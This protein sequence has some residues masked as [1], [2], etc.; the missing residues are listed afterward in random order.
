MSPKS[1]SSSDRRQMTKKP[2]AGAEPE[3]DER[4]GEQLP[5]P[6]PSTTTSAA[7]TTTTIS[8]VARDSHENGHDLK[9]GD[10]QAL[11]ETS[12]MPSEVD[13]QQAGTTAPTSSSDVNLDLLSMQAIKTT[14]TSILANNV[15][16]NEAISCSRSAELRKNNAVVIGPSTTSNKTATDPNMQ[17]L[18]QQEQRLEVDDAVG[19]VTRTA[20]N[21]V[22]SSAP[23]GTSAAAAPTVTTNPGPHYTQSEAYHYRQRIAEYNKN[24][25]WC[26]RYT[27]WTLYDGRK[28]TC[29]GF[30]K[31]RV[32]GSTTT[33]EG[34][35]HQED[36]SSSTT[37]S[38]TS[39]QTR[40][41]R[42]VK[43]IEV[44]NYL[45]ISSILCILALLSVVL[46]IPLGIQ[47]VVNRSSVSILS[48]SLT[49]PSLTTM[50]LASVMQ[51]H[52][53][54]SGLSATLDGFEV[55]MRLAR[56]ER[57]S[58]QQLSE[59]IN[60]RTT[61]PKDD[62]DES[63][64][65]GTFQQP[66]IYLSGGPGAI[67]VPVE[68]NFTITNQEN[69]V[70]LGALL[71]AS[72]RLKI[73][74]TGATRVKKF[75]GWVNY[76]VAF[77][78]T[79]ELVGLNHLK[80]VI[81]LKTFELPGEVEID[82]GE[83]D[84][85]ATSSSSAS[86]SSSRGTRSKKK[87]KKVLSVKASADIN[88]PTNYTLALGYKL[89]LQCLYKNTSM[90]Y[91]ELENFTLTPGI[92]KNVTV[93]G[94]FNPENLDVAA[95]F[96]AEFVNG[97]GKETTSSTPGGGIASS[98]SDDR[99]HEADLN[100]VADPDAEKMHSQARALPPRRSTSGAGQQLQG[101]AGHQLDADPSESKVFLDAKGVSITFYNETAA[102]IGKDPEYKI[103]WFS[104][105]VESM[106][107]ST[108]LTKVNG[109]EFVQGVNITEIG[110]NVPGGVDNLSAF[111]ELQINF[112]IPF[113]K[114]D[115]AITNLGANMTV[116]L[117]SDAV[118]AVAEMP[119][120]KIE[121]LPNKTD[122]SG[123]L[124][125]KMP[126]S[127]V[128]L[129]N[130][131]AFNNLIYSI[132]N[133]KSVELELGGVGSATMSSCL[134]SKWQLHSIPLLVQTKIQGWNR[135]AGNGGIKVKDID[136]L[137]EFTDEHNVNVAATIE[138]EN[139]T[140][141]SAK[142]G[143][144]PAHLIVTNEDYPLKDGSVSL[145]TV[146]AYEVGLKSWSLNRIRGN[147]VVDKR[148]NG[149][150]PH[151]VD[152]RTRPSASMRS[153]TAPR[154]G[155]DVYQ[156]GHENRN[157]ML[158]DHVQNLVKTALQNTGVL[159]TGGPA[160]ALQLQSIPRMFLPPTPT[161]LSGP[162]SADH[163]GAEGGQ[164]LPSSTSAFAEA[165]AAA[166][167]EY[168]RSR[169]PP[170]S[171]TALPAASASASNIGGII[172]NG[173]SNSKPLSTRSKD[174]ITPVLEKMLG[175]HLSNRTVTNAFACGAY[176]KLWQNL[177]FLQP[178]TKK[179][180][181]I[182][183]SVPG[184]EKNLLSW[185]QVLLG[186]QVIF[187]KLQALLTIENT[188]S[189]ALVVKN[190]YGLVYVGDT[191]DL[192]FGSVN[193]SFVNATSAGWYIPA[194]KN[195]TSDPIWGQILL[196]ECVTHPITCGKVLQQLI[197]NTLATLSVELTA[198]VEGKF[199]LTV[200]ATEKN[201]PMSL[202]QKARMVIGG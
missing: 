135:F 56:N 201:V 112:K 53:S 101:P 37:S 10:L 88:N 97:T 22:V 146:Q 75:N 86:T 73:R 114:F 130:V 196:Q 52:P 59:K 43:I 1:K 198:A 195:A 33:A 61:T 23:T 77:D 98:S 188:F 120:T 36:G 189:S 117:K 20:L 182:S 87:K 81:D 38:S 163:T 2:P 58:S 14:S 74:V 95:D 119:L 12:K 125:I 70:K 162:V 165:P 172:S 16:S 144:L 181:D 35:E 57:G 179:L 123:V 7:T 138:L 31:S 76:G 3:A 104:K 26:F 178:V 25:C 186:P 18:E 126:S 91:V 139:Q 129:Q 32:G 79:V 115:Y 96:L 69:M 111:G 150:W 143:F 83:D 66:S 85:S 118:N 113:A 193:V 166:A 183:V 5:Q 177:T 136:I 190:A 184:H 78:Q 102:K 156:Q 160:Q 48:M 64:A 71:L 170:P 49:S 92:T 9:E 6:S 13:F 124:K 72:K 151:G 109:R 149:T 50:K 192:L 94:I 93:T 131:T 202:H 68:S 105:L 46:F 40:P 197:G 99:H 110:F 155:F 122:H 175:M 51:L 47:Q 142:L 191:Q 134:S 84:T 24:R 152:E 121:Y 28:R 65:I 168:H 45:L 158:R 199:E 185:I 54:V 200:N 140:P 164:L 39:S 8:A 133:E 107:S 42:E 161:T 154:P 17:S 174:V 103:P 159:E 29:F 141:L 180:T 153:I 167:S 34:Q 89:K 173:N 60:R 147:I 63:D 116:R 106:T 30:R 100:L 137:P 4:T 187:L 44:Q 62:K 11:R 19:V 157:L 194:K 169:L 145:G 55:T 27:T 128:Q 171:A 15:T 90:S 21:S 148:S 108:G 67:E 127:K 41:R 132:Y 82:D 80:N 176:E